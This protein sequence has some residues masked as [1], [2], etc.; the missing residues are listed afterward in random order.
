MPVDCLHLE[1]L[2]L[3]V[4]RRADRVCVVAEGELDAGSA[5][6]LVAAVDRALDDD[7][8]RTIVVDLTGV[9]FVD[10]HGLRALDGLVPAARGQRVEVRPSRAAD[11]L[12]PAIEKV[13]FQEPVAPFIE[14]RTNVACARGG[15]TTSVGRLS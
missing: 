6:D 3:A 13:K 11:R 14:P 8:I 5:V 1:S 9:S 12:R 15:V 7:P 2:Q 10:L 4:V